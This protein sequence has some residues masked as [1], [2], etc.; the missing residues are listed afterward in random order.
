[1]IKKQSIIQINTFRQIFWVKF[2]FGSATSAY[3]TQLFV[4]NSAAGAGEA[5]SQLQMEVL[6]FSATCEYQTLLKL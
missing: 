3:H 5:I 2:M 1:M 4:N 6:F